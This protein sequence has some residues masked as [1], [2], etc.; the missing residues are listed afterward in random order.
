MIHEVVPRPGGDY[1]KRLSRTVSATTL[2]V[3]G[4]GFEAGQRICSATAG[5][6]A[7][8]RIGGGRRR[9]HDLAELMIVPAVGIIVEHHQRGVGPFRLSLQEVGHFHHKLLLI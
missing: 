9:V 7:G 3:R 4:G 6:R 5:S 1:E 2:S 8:E